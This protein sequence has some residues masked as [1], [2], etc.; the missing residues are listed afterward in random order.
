MVSRW[1][2]GSIALSEAALYDTRK[3]VM[4]FLRS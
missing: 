1:S 4:K 2:L 3:V